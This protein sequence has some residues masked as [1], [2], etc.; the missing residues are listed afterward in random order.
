MTSKE[1]SK[2]LEQG[3]DTVIVGLGAVEQ[4]GPH[5]A[6][7]TD[8]IR[9]ED[10]AVGV[11]VKLGNALVAPVIRPGYSHQHLTFPGTISLRIETLMAIIE[12]YCESLA[13][14]GFKNIVFISTHDANGPITQIAEKKLNLEWKKARVIFIENAMDYIPENVLHADEAAGLHAGKRETSIMLAIRPDLV[15][16]KEAVREVPRSLDRSYLAVVGSLPWKYFTQSGI[17]GDATQA[18]KELGEKI[19]QSQYE[20][21]ASDVKARIEIAKEHQQAK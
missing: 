18:N 11:A 13:N 4:H 20:L 1:V 9:A 12:D 5:M 3:K 8:A 21:I 19:L 10:I 14:Q 17:M 16:M 15:N 6:T 7:A 2:A